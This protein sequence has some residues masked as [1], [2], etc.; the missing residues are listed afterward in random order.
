MEEIILMCLTVLSPCRN[1]KDTLFV[2]NALGLQLSAFIFSES[3]G[4][5]F[6]LQGVFCW[7]HKL[8]IREIYIIIYIKCEVRSTRD[9]F[10]APLHCNICF[11]LLILPWL[12]IFII[13]LYHNRC[14]PAIKLNIWHQYTWSANYQ[15]IVRDPNLWSVRCQ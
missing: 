6:G 9:T 14:I 8:D 5:N 12:D 15:N 10:N 13:F 4:R 2:H 11:V 1:E 3:Q 7:K